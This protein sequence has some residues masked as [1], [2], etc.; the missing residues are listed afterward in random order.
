MYLMQGGR[1]TVRWMP[2]AVMSARVGIVVGMLSC[3]ASAII[4]SPVFADETAAPSELRT[5]PKGLGAHQGLPALGTVPAG[6]GNPDVHS[7][8][9]HAPRGPSNGRSMPTKRAPTG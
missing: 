2:E 1:M 8:S 9:R 3:L 6:N 4:V 7:P 5:A